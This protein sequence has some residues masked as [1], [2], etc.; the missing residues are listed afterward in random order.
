MIRSFSWSTLLFS[1]SNV[2]R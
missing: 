2:T 1:T